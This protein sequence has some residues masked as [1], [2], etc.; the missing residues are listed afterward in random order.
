MGEYQ[1]VGFHDSV[2]V[3]D[4]LFILNP[5]RQHLVTGRRNYGYLWSRFGWGGVFLTFFVVLMLAIG[6]PRVIN[7]VR[8]ATM[9]TAS[10]E[11]KVADHRVSHGKSTTYTIT[12]ELTIKGRTYSH[13][14]SVSS[15][16]Y[17]AWPIGT[18]VNVT[19]AVDD[20][21]TSHLGGAG[22]NWGSVIYLPIMLGILLVISVV[23]WL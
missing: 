16:E 11:A 22:F 7:E 12:Y 6:M 20:P 4:D 19:Y 23:W 21:S 18:Y 8:L 9:R 10:G 3:P 15:S 13:D 5:M 17:N 14:E 1:G 2:S